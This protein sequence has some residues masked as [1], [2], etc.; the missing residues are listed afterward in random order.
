MMNRTQ[1]CVK[2]LQRLNIC[3]EH[4]AGS[5]LKKYSEILWLFQKQNRCYCRA[6]YLRSCFKPNMWEEQSMGSQT[7][8]I[9]R[10]GVWASI[11][12]GWF[13]DPSQNLYCNTFHLYI[14]LFLLCLPFSCY[15]VSN[16]F[17]YFIENLIIRVVQ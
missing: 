7:L 5:T 8:E 3:F 6:K 2:L 9:I 4:V 12:G 11:T 13:Y 16:L 14:W 17:I 15:V 10:Q 1:F